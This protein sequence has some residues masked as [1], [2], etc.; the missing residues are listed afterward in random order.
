MIHE[1]WN[2]E[3]QTLVKEIDKIPNSNISQLERDAL[4]AVRKIGN[5][6]AHPDTI[7]EVDSKDAELTIRI[8]EIFLQKWYIDEPASQK[9]LSTAIEQVNQ[10]K[11]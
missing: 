5:I 3:L 4:H 6:G 10:G 7:L 11:K 1:R 8:I 9:M 2:I